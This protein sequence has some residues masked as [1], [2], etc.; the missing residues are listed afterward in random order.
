MLL[1]TAHECAHGC[2]QDHAPQYSA[3]ATTAS[4]SDVLAPLPNCAAPAATACM[5]WAAGRSGLRHTGLHKHGI[6]QRT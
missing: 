1:I 4:I 2:A 3:R 5:F 6:G